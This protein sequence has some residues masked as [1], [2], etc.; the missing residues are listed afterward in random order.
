MIRSGFGRS[1]GSDAAGGWTVNDPL[2]LRIVRPFCFTAAKVFA[3]SKKETLGLF[4]AR[5]APKNPPTEP[6]PTISICCMRL[7]ATS[8]DTYYTTQ[9]CMTEVVYNAPT[10]H[11]ARRPDSSRS[12]APCLRSVDCRIDRRGD[13]RGQWGSNVSWSGRS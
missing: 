2:A 3:R 12:C 7:L 11:V 4:F 1:R 9:A 10:H 5:W 6:A 8:T 13:L